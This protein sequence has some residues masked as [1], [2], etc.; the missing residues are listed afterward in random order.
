MHGWFFES[1]VDVLQLLLDKEN[2]SNFVLLHTAAL[3]M[4]LTHCNAAECIIELGSWLGRS[5][6]Y[7]ARNAPNAVIFAIDIW[8]NSVIL[9]DKHY[10][11]NPENMAILNVGPLHERFMSN[12]W[13]YKYQVKDGKVKGMLPMHM[14]A[15]EGLR[16]LKDAGVEPDVVYVDASHHFDG[17]YRDIG[18]TLDLFPGAHI[19]GDDY[20]YPDVRRAVQQLARERNLDVFESGNKCWTFSRDLCLQQRKKRKLKE[21]ELEKSTVRSVQRPRIE[22][23][24]SLKD[25][26]NQYKKK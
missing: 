1:H 3:D 11:N 15:V 25:L 13:E 6:E 19:V 21:E 26:L 5:A 24:Q 10:C 20:D 16:I 18:M 22:G 23:K 7:F 9:A 12:M 4:I 2:T 14:D 8:D 17:V